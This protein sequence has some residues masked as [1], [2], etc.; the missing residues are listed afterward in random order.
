M[1][2]LVL[3]ILSLAAVPNVGFAQ[4]RAEQAK[5]GIDVT[6]SREN[7]L[8][9]RVTLTSA[10][11]NEVKLYR[12]E[13]PWGNRYSMVF[14]AAKPN[15]EALELEWPIDDPG[16]SRIT[17]KAGDTLTGEI[18]LHRVIR[19]LNALKKSDVLLFWG[20]KTP[21]ALHLPRWTGGLVIIPQ[22]K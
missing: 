11:A 17:V 1:R 13:L 14:T 16:P 15:S 3:A 19:D 8:H 22:Q 6:L 4:I 20:Y 21:A 7:P 10:A 18:D 12:S 9:L 2:T 5:A